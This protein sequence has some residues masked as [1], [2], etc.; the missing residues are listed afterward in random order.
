M[1]I[2]EILEIVGEREIPVVREH[3]TIRQVLEKMLEHPHT[4]LMYV[5]DEDHICKGIISLG[6]L[7]R[8]L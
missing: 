4:R 5:V 3:D 2:R 6:A 8:H 1:K 7:I